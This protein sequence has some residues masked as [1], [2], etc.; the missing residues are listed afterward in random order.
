MPIFFFAASRVAIV[1]FT[2]TG[3]SLYV[4]LLNAFKLTFYQLIYLRV[5]M[6]TSIPLK[7]VYARTLLITFVTSL[8]YCT[9][10][11][12]R[13]LPQRDVRRVNKNEHD[14]YGNK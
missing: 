11:V 14:N 4:K 7:R 8:L 2:R 13:L 9:G 5:C 3:T 10:E 12:S 1:A 6:C